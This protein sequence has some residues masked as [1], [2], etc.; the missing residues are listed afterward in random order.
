MRIKFTEATYIRGEGVDVGDVREEDAPLARALIASRRAVAV[1][2]VGVEG[3][4]AAPEQAAT[5][6]TEAA[7]TVVTSS[8][9]RRRG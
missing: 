5:T 1:V 8:K 2:D 7:V 4:P 6:G 9:P 3:A